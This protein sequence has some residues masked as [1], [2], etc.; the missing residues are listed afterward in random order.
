MKPTL[1]RIVLFHVPESIQEKMGMAN[2][3]NTSKLLPATIVAVWSET[4]INLKVHL[5]GELDGH[6][7]LWMTSVQEGTDENH[8]EWP[9]IEVDKPYSDEKV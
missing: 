4:T 9:V 5:D 6:G 2:G 3:C 7:D 1:G 8:W